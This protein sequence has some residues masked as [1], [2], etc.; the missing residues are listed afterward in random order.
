MSD[1]MWQSLVDQPSRWRL[2][3]GA[4]LIFLAICAVT[5]EAG[6]SSFRAWSVSHP[7]AV[8]IGVGA[9]LVLFT[10]L[11]IEHAIG[12]LEARRWRIPSLLAI[13]AYVYSADRA[14]QRIH[15]KVKEELKALDSPPG[16][17]W[18]F[19]LNEAL[20][21]LVDQNCLRLGVLSDFVREE[22]DELALIAMQVGATASRP[23]HFSDAIE[24]IFREQGRLA[25][26]AELCH[27]LSFLG[28]GL[29]GPDAT[30]LRQ[31][32]AARATEA[33]DLME[34]FLTELSALRLQV[35]EQGDLYGIS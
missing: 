16:G 25:K 6:C 12:A 20:E 29:S 8:A 34:A 28:S 9:G 14:A 13:D 2:T 22:T 19:R 26:M 30:A 5:A 3:I 17:T 35:G 15:R 1:P 32:A 7:V 31:Q 27:F 4:A 24:R 18:V 21:L 11:V 33:G 23:G 10:A